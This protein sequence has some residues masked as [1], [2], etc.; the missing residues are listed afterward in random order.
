M[1]Q[2]RLLI[3]AVLGIVNSEGTIPVGWADEVLER[4][5]PGDIFGGGA[6]FDAGFGAHA[7][8]QA[9]RL[10]ACLLQSTRAY[11][12][13]KVAAQQHTPPLT[14]LAVKCSCHRRLYGCDE[15]EHGILIGICERMGCTVEECAL[16]PATTHRTAGA[17][18]G[19]SD[20][21]ADLGRWI[22]AYS[23]NCSFEL[24]GGGALRDG[25]LSLHALEALLAHGSY[26]LAPFAH[27]HEDSTTHEHYD[28]LQLPYSPDTARLLNAHAAA[29]AARGIAAAAVMVDA[30]GAES[31]TALRESLHA[32]PQPQQLLRQ[33]PADVLRVALRTPSVLGDSPHA[34]A[35]LAG[36]DALQ[37]NLGKAKVVWGLKKTHCGV[38]ASCAPSYNLEYYSYWKVRSDG[39]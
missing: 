5:W 24:P 30:G 9:D 13:C 8:A 28:L 17:A 36:I 20:Q 26:H 37:A 39:G 29:T 11:D 21:P 4:A 14:S 34:A 22:H 15:E 1:W 23:A 2:L 10:K 16:P 6:A 27:P 33:D 31:V 18:R 25:R 35:L 3:A 32:P 38:E 7:D 12:A 19:D